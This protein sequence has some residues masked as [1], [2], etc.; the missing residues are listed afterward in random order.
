VTPYAQPSDFILASQLLRD[1]RRK[2][3]HHVGDLR[4]RAHR[5]RQ[6]HPRRDRCGCARGGGEPGS[7]R[8]PQPAPC[9]AGVA[10][11]LGRSPRALEGSPPPAYDT[12]LV[13]AVN[14]PDRD[15]AP[16]ACI[17]V[18]A[19]FV[20]NQPGGVDRILDAHRRRPDGSCTCHAHT[21][22]PWPCSAVTIAHAAQQHAAVRDPA[23]IWPP[24]DVRDR[25]VSP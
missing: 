23:R 21:V 17:A 3:H 13:A 2:D 8:A 20:A 19:R 24:A 1:R 12:G 10:A 16:A 25:E 22:T 4:P 14:P 15:D 6:D 5:R 11:D 18:A 9:P 7:G